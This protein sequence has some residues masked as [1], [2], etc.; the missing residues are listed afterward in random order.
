MTAEPVTSA[1]MTTAEVKLSAG[2]WRFEARVS[3]PAGP[4]RLVELLPVAR[5]MADSA[6]SAVVGEIESQGLSI[7]CKKGCGACCRQLVP[8]SEVEARRLRDVVEQMPEPRRSQ[9]R[10][11]FAQARRAIEEAGLLETIRHSERW[12]RDG[13]RPMGMR[14]FRLGIPC[15]FLEE[16]SCSIYTERPITCREF[17][18]VTPPENCANPEPGR[19]RSV[20]VPLP[21]AATLA[22]FDVPPSA[23][24]H[25]R[26]VP[27]V[28][29][30]EWADAHTEPP[31]RPG[32]ELL[33]EL[34][35][36]LAGDASTTTEKEPEVIDPLMGSWVRERGPDGGRAWPKHS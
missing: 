2:P 13:Y 30:L 10:A 28:L 36:H 11:R 18:V 27:L 15:P 29:A 6:I 4:T 12:T 19:V 21:M 26:W 1:E 23:P 9:I 32:P 16:E 14:Y 3:V 34:F 17:L 24:T 20:R 25:E 8:I 33:S 35:Q 5:Q 31:P 7:S 22:R